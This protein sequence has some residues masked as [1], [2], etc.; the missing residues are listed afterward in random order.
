MTE[1]LTYKAALTKSMELLSSDP[2]RR[3]IG[4]GLLQGRAAGT[5]ASASEEQIV[6]TPVAENLMVGLAIGMSLGGL[7]PVVYIERM[8]FILN[9]LD[10]IVNHLDKIALMSKGKF[11]PAVI[12]RVVVGNKDCPL[13]TGATHTQNFSVAINKM[14][15]FS[16]VE[17]T[18][19]DQT[20]TMYDVARS[21]QLEGGSTMLVE[22]KDLIQMPPKK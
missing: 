16:V 3:F 17:L 19:P 11:N 20:L 15:S 2:K 5:L 10:A 8:D 13:Y 9:A 7:L 22:F 12:L 21:V 18:E 14:V 4:Y 1:E 6:E